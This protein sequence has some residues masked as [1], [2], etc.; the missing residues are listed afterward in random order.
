FIMSRTNPQATIVSKE[1]L[2]P[3]ANRLVIK[4]N[5]QRVALDSD[6]TDTM[7]RFDEF[8]WKTVD[9]S[10]RPLKMSKLLY[11]R[12][13]KL[14]INHFL[15]CNNSIP[16]RSNSELHSAQ[17]DQP[18]TKLSNTVKGD[19]KFGME[20]LDTMINDE[21]KKLA[22]YNYHI[23]KKKKSAKDKIVDEPEE[24]RVSPVKNERGKGFM[25]YGEL[26]NSISIQGPRTLQRQ[27]SQLAIDSQIDDAVVDTYAKLESLKQKKQTVAREGSK[28]SANETD[29]ADDSDMDLSD[30]NLQGNDDAAGFGMFIYIKFTETP[31]STYFS[32]IVT[33]SLLDFIQNLLNETPVNELIDFEMFP[34]ENAHHK[35]SLPA[36]KIPYNA[37]TPQPSSLQAKAKKLTQKEKKNMRKINFKKAVAYKFREYDQKLEAFK[38]LMFLKHLK[39]LSKQEF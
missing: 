24:Q 22:G 39:K 11:T 20:I 1:Q 14:I 19:Y 38:I 17:D 23:A 8:E 6:I 37:T 15:S 35:P 30:D 18:I 27:R 4:K 36:K 28:E 3:R 31:N 25:C 26:A 34:D 32:P 33:S 2:V 21:I 12:F 10:S 7:L 29:D 5:N 16:R 9:K 13:T